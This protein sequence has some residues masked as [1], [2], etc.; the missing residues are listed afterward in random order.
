MMMPG[1]LIGAPLMGGVGP[2]RNLACAA[3]HLI[4]YALQ[5][6][7]GVSVP[8]CKLVKI[9]DHLDACFLGL[10]FSALQMG[11]HGAYSLPGAVGRF[12]SSSGKPWPSRVVRIGVYAN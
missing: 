11:M 7:L 4:W 8:L 10:I 12:L 1:G 2:L 6:A 9:V 3:S 5:A